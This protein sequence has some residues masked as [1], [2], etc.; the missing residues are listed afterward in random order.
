MPTRYLFVNQTPKLQSI[1]LTWM[2]YGIHYVN[3][4]KQTNKLFFLVHPVHFYF[5]FTSFLLPFYFLRPSAPLLCPDPF[6]HFQVNPDI[7]YH[8][9][10]L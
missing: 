4:D 8:Q 3:S 2:I 1:S 9:N 5:L 7:F 10:M 6:V